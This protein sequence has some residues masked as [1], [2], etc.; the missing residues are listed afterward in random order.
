MYVQYKA[1]AAVPWFDT[2][3]SIK[4]DAISRLCS[5]DA[6]NMDTKDLI[7]LMHL[8]DQFN[9]IVVAA[10][11]ACF[12]SGLSS[13]INLSFPDSRILF[14]RYFTNEFNS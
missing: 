12:C 1:T 10:D 9:R 8:I 7:I 2:L 13:L 11:Q 6:I 4:F 14:R 5:R 3:G